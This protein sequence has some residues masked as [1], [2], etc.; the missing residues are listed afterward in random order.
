AGYIGGWLI[1]DDMHILDLAVDPSLRRQGV[2]SSLLSHILEDAKALGAATAS[3][4]VRKTNYAA[5]ALYTRFGFT[6]VGTRPAYY[7]PPV[8]GG[9]REDALILKCKIV[10]QAP[11]FINNVEKP[12]PASPEDDD[13]AGSPTGPAVASQNARPVIL[14]IETSCDET[15]AAVI[16]GDGQIIA[17]AIAS[18]VDYHARFGGVV[19]EIA[20][21]KHTEAIV[22]VVDE[23]CEQAKIT[24]W[25]GLDA[26]AVTYAPGLIGA[27]V[28]GVAFAK[29][30]A[31]ATN[32]PLV[33]VNHMEGHIYANRLLAVEN[34]P[35]P[36]ASGSPDEAPRASALYTMGSQ[37]ASPFVI[38]LLSGGHTM[39]V[40]VHDWAVYK[41]LGQTLDDAVGEAFDKVAKA[42]GLGYPGGPVISSLALQG[43][44]EAISFP[45][46]LMHSNDFNFSL[47]G[48][49][50]AVITWIRNQQE[51]GIAI[52]PADV[53]ASFQQA[54][55]DVQVS[56]ALAACQQMKVKTFCL[57]GGVAANQALREAYEQAFSATGIQ[58]LFPPLELCS[59]N[60]AMIAAAA[61]DR[62]NRGL[63]IQF[64]SDALAQTDLELDY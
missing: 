31:W 57:G 2:A 42:L 62:Y 18:Q 1:D 32:L 54:V 45:R 5:I 6:Q 12:Q 52:N 43:S 35:E 4:E 28:V 26:I 7:S 36:E 60:A 15:A 51:A 39:L 48:L 29:G 8:P 37:P 20:S 58:L 63:F 55:I 17:N 23:A 21:R 49:K 34:G 25:E 44:P 19:P 61:L 14:A 56:K 40:Y 38:S 27:L 11:Y 13:R 47:S 46:A 59:D 33:R 64:D 10:Q 24:G 9:Q 50:T 22:G 16:T 30:L 53:A 3:L 41:V